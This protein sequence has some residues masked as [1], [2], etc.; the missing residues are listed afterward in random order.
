MGGCSDVVDLESSGGYVYVVTEQCSAQA[1]S[2]PG[3]L[4]RTANATGAFQ[5]VATVNLAPEQGDAGSILAIHDTTGFL[6]TAA[7]TGAP[8]TPALLVT[9]NGTTWSPEP[10][11]CPAQLDEISVAP[12]DTV[13]AAMLC[14]GQGAAGS[15]TKAVLATSDGGHSWVPEGSAPPMGGDGGTLSAATVSI[16]AIATSSGAT[17]IYRSMN[18]GATWTTALSLDDGGEGWG[19]LGFTDSTHGF[20]IHAPIGRYQ[21]GTGAPSADTGTMYSTSDAGVTW[22]AVLF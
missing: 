21:T 11:P 12:V 19:R 14:S 18:G 3:Q 17:E 20:A 16:L 4:W 8:G 9:E 2:C 22:S 7:T 1:S 15:S 5:S 13:R 10:N 6:V